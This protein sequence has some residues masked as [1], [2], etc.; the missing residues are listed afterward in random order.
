[1]SR[2]TW[3]GDWTSWRT[4]FGNG[5]AARRSCSRPLPPR[6]S[7]TAP[8]LTP[9]PPL[10]RYLNPGLKL[11]LI[12]ERPDAAATAT[13]TKAAADGDTGDAASP[14]TVTEEGHLRTT[15]K[16]DGGL[17]EM[18]QLL[19]RDKKP[20]HETFKEVMVRTVEAND[21]PP[22]AEPGN[23]ALILP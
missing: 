8:Q 11:T 18:V 21:A 17:A 15:F 2:R 16:H 4:F 1:M 19:V 9:S 12:E 3:W 14:Q 10:P 23:A 20:V 5:V 13:Q 7:S 22:T 6:P